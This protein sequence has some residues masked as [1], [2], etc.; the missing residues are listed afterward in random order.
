M[1]AQ[2]LTSTTNLSLYET[3]AG[4]LNVISPGSVL[5]PSGT[6]PVPLIVPVF[7]IVPFPSKLPFAISFP[8][9]ISL[10][11]SP[12]FIPPVSN[13][14]PSTVVVTPCAISRIFTFII[15]PLIVKSP[16][17]INPVWPVGEVIVTVP[18][19]S[20]KL[21]FWPWSTATLFSPVISKLPSDI[22]TVPNA[23]RPYFPFP[24]AVTDPPLIF[25]VPFWV[26]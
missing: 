17:V 22:L 15:P 19:E 11:L 6:C 3:S 1:L 23:H 2:V 25:K 14:P 4:W 12:I 13:I 8:L 20:V 10:P 18:P 24:F 26:T 9:F 7:S 21:E 5:F 16:F